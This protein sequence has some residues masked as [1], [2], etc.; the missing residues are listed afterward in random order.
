M[1]SKNKLFC[2]MILG[3]FVQQV[4]LGGDRS[5]GFAGASSSAIAG[6]DEIRLDMGDAQ[7]MGPVTTQVCEIITG[8]RV[9]IINKYKPGADTRDLRRFGSQANPTTD[10]AA[11]V[12][13]LA[14][15]LRDSNN[16]RALNDK[17]QDN[18]A[19][20]DRCHAFAFNCISA[21]LG[22]GGLALSIYNASSK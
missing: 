5:A 16:N 17:R 14:H 2:G 12:M 8:R 11:S 3:L 9:G 6:H 4:I 18:Q 7:H 20:R 22:I 19:R 13:T 21:A 15:A 1:P 10:L